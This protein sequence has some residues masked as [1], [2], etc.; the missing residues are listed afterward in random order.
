LR[1]LIIFRDGDHVLSFLLKKGFQHCFV[2][3]EQNGL[4]IQIDYRAGVPDIRYLSQSDFDLA[5]FYRDQG[6]TVVETT[7]GS[8]PATFPFSLRN[9]VGMAK[10]ILCINNFALTP[11]GLY[12]REVNYVK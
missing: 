4:W 9:C 7:Q 12:K 5:S 10:Q 2:C 1:A 3:I 8:K 6:M 11:Y